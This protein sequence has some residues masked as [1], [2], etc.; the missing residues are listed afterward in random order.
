MQIWRPEFT[1]LC[2]PHARLMHVFFVYIPLA[3]STP[4][5]LP[6]S[7]LLVLDILLSP[8][9]FRPLIFCFSLA[10]PIPSHFRPPIPSSP[11][12]PLSLPLFRPLSLPISHPLSPPPRF[13]SPT[14]PSHYR[15]LYP[16]PL[17]PLSPLL[18]F[19]PLYP[20][21]LSSVPYP[22]LPISVPCPLGYTAVACYRC[23]SRRF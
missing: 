3:L 7:S 14:P 15:L 2:S 13:C 19:H 23:R 5:P 6:P 9:F 16:S 12:T 18:L 11:F 21:L 4:L 17:C 20:L 8:P 1:A 22:L 10:F